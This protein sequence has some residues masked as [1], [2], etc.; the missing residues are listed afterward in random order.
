V[1]LEELAHELVGRDLVVTLVPHGGG[2]ALKF[3]TLP[4]PDWVV[5]VQTLSDLAAGV[6]RG[7]VGEGDELE[8]AVRDA[9]TKHDER[10][11]QQ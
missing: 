4:G 8:D 5:H 10:E 3:C 7:W 9:L 2:H 6:P 11:P 1:T